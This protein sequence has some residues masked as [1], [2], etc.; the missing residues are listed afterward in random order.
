MTE[1]DV[2]NPYRTPN[3][4]D[5]PSRHTSSTDPK[6]VL[7]RNYIWAYLWYPVASVAITYQSWKNYTY[8]AV[9]A[10]ITVAALGCLIDAVVRRRSV[11]IAISTIPGFVFQLVEN[12]LATLANVL[13]TELI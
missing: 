9:L 2:N 12:I 1:R 4:T 6:R 5:E 11:W 13:G 8:H 7:C 10:C 3:V